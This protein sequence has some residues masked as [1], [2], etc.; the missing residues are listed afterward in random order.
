MDV[1]IVVG[2]PSESETPVDM[3]L[4]SSSSSLT[5]VEIARRGLVAGDDD[6]RTCND[7]E[8]KNEINRPEEKPEK[9]RRRTC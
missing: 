6:D 9:Q 3:G 7:R 2:L 8:R 1:R 5:T 4:T